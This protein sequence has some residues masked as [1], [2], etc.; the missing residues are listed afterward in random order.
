VNVEKYRATCNKLIRNPDD[1]V[2]LVDQF[3]LISEKKENAALYLRS[4]TG[5]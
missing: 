5:F 1:A 4:P 3:S 2:A